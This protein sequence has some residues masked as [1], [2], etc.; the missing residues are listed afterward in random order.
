M[1]VFAAVAAAAAAAVAVVATLVT[2]GMPADQSLKIRRRRRA[3]NVGGPVVRRSENATAAAAG[4]E[5]DWLRL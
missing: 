2:C 4:T 3:P 1:T 5:N